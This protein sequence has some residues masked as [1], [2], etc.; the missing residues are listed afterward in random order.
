MTN[1][2]DDG[3]YI[4]DFTSAGPKN[5]GYKTKSGKVC[6]LVRG[7]TFNVRGQQQ[8]NYHIMRQNLL[9]EL[10]DPLDERRNI[11]VI[12]PISSPNSSKWVHA[13][14]DMHWCLTNVWSIRTPS[15][16]ILM[17]T[18][19]LVSMMWTWKMLKP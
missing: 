10:T 4:I 19:H 16:P 8:L 15:S 6:C 9:E 7:F 17:D 13:P 3:D 11:D 12:N 1:E 5:Y 18:H 2:L 14:N